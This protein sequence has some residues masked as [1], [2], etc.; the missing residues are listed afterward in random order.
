MWYKNTLSRSYSSMKT[1][2]TS[3]SSNICDS[4]LLSSSGD[5]FTN[6]ERS[7]WPSTFS[8]LPSIFSSDFDNTDFPKF[9]DDQV[10]YKVMPFLKLTIQKQA[11]PPKQKIK[12]IKKGRKP[13][14][15]DY[16]QPWYLD[17]GSNPNQNR[18]RQIRN[19]N[20]KILAFNSSVK[21]SSLN[22]N[23]KNCTC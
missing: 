9:K 7:L 17:V 3:K 11:K 21:K 10:K 19:F 1:S 6:T 18:D 20:L 4:S 8:R 12:A 2:E 23:L 22:N 5:K 15:Q 16:S 14:N 13:L